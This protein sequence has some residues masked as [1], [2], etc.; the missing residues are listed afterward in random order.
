M[1]G[2]NSTERVYYLDPNPA[3]TLPTERAICHSVSFGVSVLGRTDGFP[4]TSLDPWATVVGTAT[5]GRVQERTLIIPPA[6]ADKLFNHPKLFKRVPLE[7][8]ESGD[9]IAFYTT[10]AT[11]GGIFPEGGLIHSFPATS[12][13]ALAPPPRPVY[14]TA[15]TPRPVYDI[16]PAPRPVYDIAP[17]PRPTK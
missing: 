1:N 15:P 17:P 9:I 6:T 5:I 8:I 3:K 14:D 13:I 16:A 4:I 2:I 10:V 11:G 7:E 12:V